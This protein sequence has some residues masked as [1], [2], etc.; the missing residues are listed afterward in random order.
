MAEDIFAGVFS[1][2]VEAVHV[3]LSDEGVDVAM[4]EVFREDMVLE[5][6]DLFDGKLTS[7]GHPVYD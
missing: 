6:I 5:V 2:F 7:V 1:A 3:K 4:T